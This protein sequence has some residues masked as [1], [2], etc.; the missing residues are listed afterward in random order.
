MI[1]P[2]EM[3][4]EYGTDAVRISL[5]ACA[6]QTPQI[7]LDRR[8]FE[9]F[10]N[11]ANKI[12]N[13]ARFVFMNLEGLNSEEL[14]KGIEES[15]LALE[16]RWILSAM[17]RLNQNINDHLT[18]Y[19]FDQA[20]ELSYNFFWN[21]FCAYYVEIAKPILFQKAGTAHERRN[22][23]KILVIVLTNLIRLLHPMAPFITEELFQL[24]KTRFPNLTENTNVDLY[25]K[26]TIASLR[27]SACIVAPYPQLINRADIHPEIEER[28]ARLEQIVYTIRNIRAEMGIPPAMATDLYIVGDFSENPETLRALVRL[29]KIVCDLPSPSRLC[30]TGVI[31]TLKFMIPLPAEFAHKEKT[32]LVKERE[33]LL[34]SK[35]KLSALLNNPAFH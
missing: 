11:F 35:E 29:D 33:K 17:N 26:T 22:K 16:D 28:F 8:R 19:R 9:E 20:A 1:D 12:W 32:R 25:T 4:A 5:C 30:A 18:N 7:D 14:S 10:K 3:I 34:Q 15:L 2:L 27:S 23:Q 24:V 31:D 13:G 6:N 21:Q